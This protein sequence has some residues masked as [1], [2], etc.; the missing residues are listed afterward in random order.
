MERPPDSG[1]VWLVLTD[2]LTAR[3]FFG[4]GIVEGLHRRLGDRLE[5]IVLV[6]PRWL[7]TWLRRAPGLRVVHQDELFP[8]KVGPVEKVARRVDAWLDRRIGFF[9]LAI[10]FNRRNGFHAER[11]R[12]GH[13]NGFLDSARRGP[14]PEWSWIERA[15]FRWHFS[16]RRYVS[17]ALV[18]RM[19]LDCDAL[20]LANL[21]SHQSAPFL[22]A[23]RRL[24]TPTVGYVTSWDHPVG[25]GVVSPYVDRYLVQNEIMV[26]QLARYHGIARE[27]VV[28]T[29][30]P[31][32]DLY[33]RRRDPAAFAALVQ[34][35][36]L[37]P[38]R[39]VVLF[40]GNA[41][42]NAPHEGKLVMRLIEWWS[43][44]GAESRFQLL[45]RPHPRKGEWPEWFSAPFSREGLHVQ[46]GRSDDVDDLT[47]LLQHVACVVANAGTILLD[48]IANDRPAVCV[49]F[50]EGVPLEESHAPLNV[51][52]E[53]YRQLISS[54]AFLRAESFD[55]VVAGIERSL[56]QPDELA[57]KRAAVCRD[58]LGEVDGHVVER[59]VDAMLGA[60]A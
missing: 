4:Y 12:P 42:S 15:M 47:T 5:L 32:A 45:V 26:A 10:R 28:V 59:I 23:A 44:T 35:L 13:E 14:L 19:E 27:R 20:V 24:G 7:K 21:Q 6:D 25:K 54:G 49:L 40:A 39:P 58:V 52:G 48:A 46:K 34:Q 29:G 8:W 16:P 33:A 38:E 57:A 11:M 3:I 37:D 2:V 18:R 9:P 55:E 41:L 30:W 53:H 22:T 36:G 1:N 56:T 51:S 50:D 43:D 31:Q 17:R 60:P